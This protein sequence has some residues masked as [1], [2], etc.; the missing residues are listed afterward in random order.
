VFLKCEG[1]RGKIFKKSTQG[2]SKPLDDATGGGSHLIKAKGTATPDAGVKKNGTSM[3]NGGKKV[4]KKDRFHRK[5]K[6]TKSHCRILQS[7]GKSMERT[8]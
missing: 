1:K 3:R 2:G 8:K 7:L 4:V 5:L 6:G